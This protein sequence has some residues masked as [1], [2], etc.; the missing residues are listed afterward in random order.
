MWKRMCSGKRGSGGVKVKGPRARFFSGMLS[1]T[2][3]HSQLGFKKGRVCVPGV[4]EDSMSS[5]R[6]VSRSRIWLTKR[7]CSPGLA[8]A[9][10]ILRQSIVRSR[11]LI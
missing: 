5:V 11:L 6:R 1:R 10:A 2:T 3:V 9:A 4:L 7:S 8:L